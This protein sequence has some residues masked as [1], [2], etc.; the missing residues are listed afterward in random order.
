M[1]LGLTKSPRKRCRDTVTERSSS[2]F[3]LIQNKNIEN[4]IDVENPSNDD[5]CVSD[6][7]KKTH[8][9]S[10]CLTELNGL[11]P[12]NLSSHL[13]SKHPKIY[14]KISGE[15]KEPI[16]VKRAKMLNSLVEI[17]SVNG[18]SFTHLLDSG[19]TKS[20]QCQLDEL[21]AAKC[22]LNL[23][24]PNLFEVKQKLSEIATQIREKIR[25]EVHGKPLSL[26]ADIGT[27]RNRSIFG[28][29]IQ[30][31]NNGNLKVRS[32]G[33]IQLTEKHTGIYLAKMII[34][35]LKNLEIDLKQI[36]SVTTD[37]GKNI[38]KMVRDI[39]SHLVN[40]I[41]KSKV[42][43][44]IEINIVDTYDN[45]DS[46]IEQLLAQVK[47]M[48]D[49]EALERC[50]DEA[51]FSSNDT[52]LTSM[53]KALIDNGCNFVYDITGVNCAA[54]T[55]QLAVKDAIKMLDIN[56]SNV[57]ELCREACILLRL[58]STCNEAARM[59]MEYPLPR[60]ECATRWG[61][62]YIMVRLFYFFIFLFI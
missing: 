32:I 52:L 57:I 19:F 10:L 54:H 37:N 11:K 58:D 20:I 41:E 14:A 59:G 34:D 5:E 36:V 48:T 12:W 17:V 53:K 30:Y 43:N 7:K 46:E 60:L 45:I 15:K 1:D 39:Q 24:N 22:G 16:K 44:N 4:K 62:M 50:Y 13:S 56:I 38:L 47:E 3:V 42:D 28:V 26:L 55:L 35:R 23:S 8:I 9:C 31:S 25:S 27:K 18:R 29:S 40:E 61:S 51:T 21:Q 6:K 49:D 33:F 2:Y